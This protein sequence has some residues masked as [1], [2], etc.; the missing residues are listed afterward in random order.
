MWAI[1]PIYQ[2]NHHQNEYTEGMP[3]PF[4]TFVHESSSGK[5]RANED[6]L[7]PIPACLLRKLFFGSD[8][9]WHQK[10]HLSKEADHWMSNQNFVLWLSPTPNNLQ[11][12]VIMV[13]YD[14]SLEKQTCMF[15]LLNSLSSSVWGLFTISRSSCFFHS[16]QN[17]V[18]L[19]AF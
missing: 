14:C 2:G 3:V 12:L 5:K 1:V 9:K 19:H 17:L 16:A 10:G 13:A 11:F 8:C 18:G 7:P 6:A 15:F 4:E